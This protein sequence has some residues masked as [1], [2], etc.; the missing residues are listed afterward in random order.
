MGKW[1]ELLVAAMGI[2]QS[3]DTEALYLP[4]KSAKSIDKES[5]VTEFMIR[6]VRI[7]THKNPKYITGNVRHQR[8]RWLYGFEYRLF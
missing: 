6:W 4:L 2:A 1:V 8:R 7:G 3:P 5:E